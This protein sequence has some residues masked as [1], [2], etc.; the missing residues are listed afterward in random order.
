METSL[1]LDRPVDHGGTSEI[2]DSAIMAS[3]SRSPPMFIEG[4]DWRGAHPLKM[5]ERLSSR[6]RSGPARFFSHN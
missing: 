1:I 2:P 3:A 4:C 6:L 5:Q